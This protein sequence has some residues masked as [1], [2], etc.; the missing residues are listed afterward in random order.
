MYLQCIPSHVQS[1]EGVVERVTPDEGSVS[2]L[3]I[4]NR[5]TSSV[6]E[7][8]WLSLAEHQNRGR[9]PEKDFEEVQPIPKALSAVSVSRYRRF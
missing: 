9:R 1:W 7:V 3:E 4:D 6:A 2:L 5:N 8:T